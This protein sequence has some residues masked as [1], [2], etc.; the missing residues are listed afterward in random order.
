MNSHHLPFY[1]AF[2]LIYKLRFLSRVVNSIST[3][4][5]HPASLAAAIPLFIWTRGVDKM[6][7]IYQKPDVLHQ[8]VSEYDQELPQ[9]HTLQLTHGTVSKSHRTF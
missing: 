4:A 3:S 5:V 9:T 7:G 1:N 2:D 8:K 6:Y